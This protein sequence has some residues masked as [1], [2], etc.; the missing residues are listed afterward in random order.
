MIGGAARGGLTAEPCRIG[1]FGKHLRSR[2]ALD[3]VEFGDRVFERDA[4][5]VLVRI[6]RG[7]TLLHLVQHFGV[8]R[9]E[10]LLYRLALSLFRLAAGVAYLDVPVEKFGIRR[11]HF[12]DACKRAPAA[13]L[14]LR[15]I[16]IFGARDHQ[17]HFCTRVGNVEK[18][19][20]LVQILPLVLARQRQKFERVVLDPA[21]RIGR[22][23]SYAAVAVEP[24]VGS[25]AAIARI[26]ADGE[27]DRELQPLALVYRQKAHA[28]RL[29][30]ALYRRRLVR[31][32]VKIGERALQRRR[33]RLA[34]QRVDERRQHR[35]L[36]LAVGNGDVLVVVEVGDQFVRERGD[37]VLT[38]EQPVTVEPCEKVVQ[39]LRERVLLFGAVSICRL[40][41]KL[42]LA[43]RRAHRRRLFV[44]K[45]AERRQRR[46]DQLEV[47]A[48]IVD[49]R[50]HVQKPFDRL[51][52]ALLLKQRAVGGDAGVRERLGDLVHSV[53]AL[54]AQHR[55]VAVPRLARRRLAL[56][57]DV[58]IADQ[59]LYLFDDAERLGARLAHLGHRAVLGDA[60]YPV[61]RLVRKPLA[62]VAARIEQD[63]DRL[64]LAALFEPRFEHGRTLVVYPPSVLGHQPLEHVVDKLQNARIAAI[65]AVEFERRAPVGMSDVVVEFV[66]ENADLGQTEPIDALLGVPDHKGVVSPADRAQDVLLHIVCVLIFVDADIVVT[67]PDLFARLG[68]VQDLDRVVF[69]IVKVE[70]VVLAL[71]L[72]VFGDH[73]PHRLA[74]FVRIAAGVALPLRPLVGRTRGQCRHLFDE[75]VELSHALAALVADEHV[76]GIDGKFFGRAL[77][78]ALDIDRKR[79]AHRID[80]LQVVALRKRRADRLHV[81]KQ[82]PVRL[83]VAARRDRQLDIFGVFCERVGTRTQLAEHAL[84]LL[85]RRLDVVARPF[86]PC[87][88]VG[89]SADVRHHPAYRR[90]QIAFAAEIQ[91][92]RLDLAVGALA[93]IGEH[94]AYRARQKRLLF[95]VGQNGIG[96]IDARMLKKF[97]DQIAAKRVHRAYVRHRDV[98]DLT[99]QHVLVR[100]L[101]AQSRHQ[102]CRYALA[103]LRRDRRRKREHHYPLD[104]HAALD[105]PDDA[106]YHHRGLARPRRRGHDRVAIDAL[107]RGAL[108]VIPLVALCPDAHRPPSL[109]LAKYL[110]FSSPFASVVVRAASTRALLQMCP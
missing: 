83:V 79:R 74:Q 2:L 81:R 94:V 63:L 58:Q 4:H 65:V 105:Q 57:R 84:Q 54:F 10:Q 46:R 90:S 101:F 75:R 78:R 1:R 3:L 12:V 62:R 35:R 56:D 61:V 17:T 44:R 107:D 43:E 85:R 36:C 87:V 45:A 6:A 80:A 97:L 15:K 41:P 66:D 86:E 95:V 34:P 99:A 110:Y 32:L 102:L 89:L 33:V 77:A 23:Q 42:L 106:L 104:R 67:R 38:D 52:L 70:L 96:R 59:R 25:V 39:L 53:G 11:T 28:V 103:K 49:R 76:L 73:R 92:E 16:L 30:R 82:P 24:D 7:Q 48:R 51:A 19:Q 8:G 31:V 37:V 108:F 109:P 68:I 21:H 98:V 60:V 13:R 55:D 88:A 22:A 29:R 5:A 9:R 14:A 93:V 27:H 47:T 64:A 40:V 91:P 20:L 69:E 71:V 100:P 26:A 50:E 18:A 72:G